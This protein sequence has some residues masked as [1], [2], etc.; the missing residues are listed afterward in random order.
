MSYLNFY[1]PREPNPQE[2]L[3]LQTWLEWAEGGA[4]NERP[5][6]RSKGLC[7]N[8]YWHA[9]KLSISDLLDRDFPY[10]SYPFGGIGLYE[11][12]RAAG[13]LYLNKERLAWVRTVLAR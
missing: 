10:Q 1:K 13:I 6:D 2:R 4:T 9:D 5:F 11:N 8:A 3:F 7:G 12:E